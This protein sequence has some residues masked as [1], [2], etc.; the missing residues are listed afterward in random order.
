MW[1]CFTSHNKIG[2]GPGRLAASRF[3]K[4]HNN[5]IA[6]KRNSSVCHE[7]HNSFGTKRKKEQKTDGKN[8]VVLNANAARG[9]LKQS[10]D[11]SRR[12]LR[13]QRRSTNSVHSWMISRKTGTILF[14]LSSSLFVHFRRIQSSLC[15][16]KRNDEP[17]GKRECADVL[18]YLMCLKMS[19]AG[20]ELVYKYTTLYFILLPLVHVSLVRFSENRLIWYE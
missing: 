11:N 3:S 12:F 13:Q 18:A 8:F 2:C 9:N 20:F 1:T 15:D 16:S 5:T 17:D 6:Q 7:H 10:Y 19:R 14:Y 4:Y